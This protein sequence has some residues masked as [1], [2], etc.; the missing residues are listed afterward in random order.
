M[1]IYEQEVD[2]LLEKFINMGLTEDFSG[3]R[4]FLTTFSTKIQ[5]DQIKRESPP[6]WHRVSATLSTPELIAL[7]KAMSVAEGITDNFGG[8]STTPG[9]WLFRQLVARTGEPNDELA[10]W[11]LSHTNSRYL[12]WGSNNW[13]A[14]SVKEY[15]MRVQQHEEKKTRKKNERI[16]AEEQARAAKQLAIARAA[17]NNI[18]RAI[19]RDDIKAVDALIA[20]GA[21]LKVING[22]GMS[23]LEYATLLGKTEICMLLKSKQVS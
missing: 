15:R 22:D 21:D 18:W 6:Y 2:T 12:P 7:I 10:D 11:V 8:G 23:P 14:R 3:M 9:I 13:G 17:T 20:K 4:D 16:A 1:P 5:Y 19:A